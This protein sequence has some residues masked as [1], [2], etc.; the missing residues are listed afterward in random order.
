MRRLLVL[1]LLAIWGRS[2]YEV[3]SWID[4]LHRQEANFF[5]YLPPVFLGVIG[6]VIAL[7]VG[8]KIM[9]G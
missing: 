6:T 7:Y 5:A 1:P 2:I 9:K 4:Q 3:N 8:H